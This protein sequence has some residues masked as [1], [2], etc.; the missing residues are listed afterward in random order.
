MRFPVFH[1]ILFAQKF[2]GAD[3]AFVISFEVFVNGQDV[4]LQPVLT[5]EVAIT[6]VAVKSIF[7]AAMNHVLVPLV[8]GDGG[9]IFVALVAT[10][11]NLGFLVDGLAM[12]LQVI[13]VLQI[14]VAKL[15]SEDSGRNQSKI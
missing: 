14:F 2:L 4:T 9:E 7:A 13:I 5:R 3:F 1:A 10:V 15:A 8:T 11:Q 6:L 12:T